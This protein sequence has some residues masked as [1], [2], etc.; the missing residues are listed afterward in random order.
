MPNL[1][2]TLLAQMDEAPFEEAQVADFNAAGRR[3]PFTCSDQRKVHCYRVPAT[4]PAPANRRD[5]AGLRS[6]LLD[7]PAPPLVQE[8]SLQ[9][10][11]RG[12]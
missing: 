8:S 10:R 5:H 2:I 9:V 12:D 4:G 3:R 7:T 6:A 1:N 11:F